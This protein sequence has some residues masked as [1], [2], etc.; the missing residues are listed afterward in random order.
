V[1]RAE[2]GK[3]L[4]DRRAFLRALGVSGAALFVPRDAFAYRRCDDSSGTLRVG[5]VLPVQRTGDIQQAARGATLGEEEAASTGRLMGWT[6]D[7]HHIDATSINANA[8]RTGSIS[9]LIGTF[10]DESGSQLTAIAR[11]VSIPCM[12]IGCTSD[13]MRTDTCAMNLLHV[14][15]SHAM[16]TDA[17][18]R[19]SRQPLPT[20]T[21]AV[22]WH[23][24]LERYGAAQLIER[25]RVRFGQPMDGPAWAAWMAVKCVC[26]SALRSRSTDPARMLAFLNSEQA[27]FDGH[28]GWPL[29][30]RASDR[31]LRQPLY[32]ASGE[33]SGRLIGEVPERSDGTSM[34]ESLDRLGKPSASTTC[35]TG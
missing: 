19:F 18:A 9:A 15:P 27:Q 23:P 3:P 7:L 12:N 24:Q 16:K 1:N 30:F 5:L 34:R 11:D 28:K 17:L 35:V 21:R 22:A 10:G 25:F 29:S 2:A 8:I 31:Q 26:E 20:D 32:L 6:I 4:S 14:A 13:V 33:G